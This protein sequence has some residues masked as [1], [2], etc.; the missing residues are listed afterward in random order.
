MREGMGMKFKSRIRITAD[1]VRAWTNCF[2]PNLARSPHLLLLSLLALAAFPSGAQS[3]LVPPPRH[4]L[5]FH[6]GDLLYGTLHSI[7]PGGELRWNHPDVGAPI[8]F[9]LTNFSEIHLGSQPPPASR[10]ENFCHVQLVNDDELSGGLLSLDADSVVLDTWFAPGNS[11]C[12]ARVRSILPVPPPAALLFDG[13]TGLEGWTHGRVQGIE[14]SGQWRYVNGAFTASQSASLA[15][16]LKLPDR[17][18]IEFEMAWRGTFNLAIALYTD[19]LQP[20]SLR[21]KENEPDFGAFYSLQLNNPVLSVLHVSKAAP[22]KQLGQ[23]VISSFNQTNRSRI[24]IRTDRP[25]NIIALYADGALIKTWSDP[26]GF[27]AG[28]TGVRF[29][30]QGVGAVRIW[31]LR[32]T[33]WDGRFDT[34]AAPAAN[35][36]LDLARLVNHDTVV[37]PLKTLRDG[38]LVFHIGGNDIEVPL[39]RVTRVDFAPARAEAL[40]ARRGESRFFFAQRG[41]VTMELAGWDSRRMSGTSRVFGTA[42]FNPAS[43]SRIQF[44]PLP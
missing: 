23:S 10:P 21:A 5:L 27:N 31:N 4:A 18:N 37:G 30:H 35:P 1:C 12:R 14:N 38:R 2:P 20:V 44:A 3:N 33:E 39:A 40:P 24:A 7:R 19:S 11:R 13:P 29:V 42:G 9:A 22:L 16:D 28:G 26:D 43:F 32:V 34:P 6:N 36:A 15:R 41:H 17:S 25:Q 8:Q